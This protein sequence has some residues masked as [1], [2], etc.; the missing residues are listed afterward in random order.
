MTRADWSGQWFITRN[1]E[2]AKVLGMGSGLCPE[3]RIPPCYK[4]RSL[5]C[6]LD[7]RTSRASEALRDGGEGFVNVS[8]RLVQGPPFVA[9]A[10]RCVGQH[11]PR[12]AT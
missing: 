5:E 1:E 11:S 10:S 3:T 2:V 9:R 12:S 6:C 7:W 8:G 4:V